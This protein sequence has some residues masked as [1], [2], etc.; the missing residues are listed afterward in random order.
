MDT[1]PPPFFKRGPSPLARLAFFALLSLSLLIA[2]ARFKYLE[3]ARQ[4]IAAAVYPLQ[5]LAAAPGALLTRFGQFFVT[6]AAL[7]DENARLRQKALQQS[8]LLQQAQALL[9]EDTHLRQLLDA[10]PRFQGKVMLADILSAGRDPFTRKVTID[11]GSQ[12]GV[13]P[14]EAV[15][16]EVGVIGQVTRVYPWMAEVTL[17][18]DKDQAVPVQD[19][20]S[21]VRAVVFGIGQDGTLDLPYM[22]VNAD[23]QN[24]DALV[25]SGIDGTYP[26]GLPVAVVSNI[27]RNAAYAF[28]RIACTPS[29][30]VNRYS[31]VLIV[32]PPGPVPR[33]PAPEETPA[34]P[35]KSKKAH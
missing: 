21:G 24:G 35:K 16:D 22:P 29:A 12:Q 33:L 19:V 34:K 25:T 18:T 27:E 28:A 15:V 26:P 31:Q 3:V 4:A 13:T 17:I 9:A 14:G 6:Q 1:Q 30:G 23:I 20:R 2:D 10:R 7:Q 5:R 8:P 11:K 32:S